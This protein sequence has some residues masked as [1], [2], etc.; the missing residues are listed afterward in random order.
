MKTLIIVRHAKS[1]WSHPFVKDI[2][3]PLNARGYMDAYRINAWL[4][5]QKI[6]PD[7]VCCSPATRAYSTAS[8]IL[9]DILSLQDHS[10]FMIFEELYEL[11]SSNYISF[12]KNISDHYNCVLIFGHNSA[13]THTVNMLGYSI[14]N[15]PT[16]G[17][18]IFNSKTDKWKNF[19]DSP[20]E[21][22]KKIFPS[23]LK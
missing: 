21:F 19:V 9:R 2:D 18:F 23:E 14:D 20:P 13:I 1:D 5:K 4:K 15:V 3:R 12:I 10:R 8:I 17:L 22:E 11:S 7:G 6:Q 16:C